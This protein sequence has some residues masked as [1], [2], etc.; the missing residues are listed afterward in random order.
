MQHWVSNKIAVS[1]PLI[2]FER[3]SM[4][5]DLR[6][7]ADRRSDIATLQSVVRPSVVTFGIVRHWAVM[8]K[9]MIT[10]DCYD[11]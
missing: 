11:E 8:K 2:N 1:I 3:V 10:N 4:G 7:V 6:S 5:I 9:L